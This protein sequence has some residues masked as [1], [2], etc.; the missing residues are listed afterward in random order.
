MQLYRA[1]ASKFDAYSIYT[2]TAASGAMRAYGMPQVT[3]AMESHMDDIAR[4][5]GMDPIE[6]RNRNR[7]EVGFRD[8]FTGNVNWTDSHGAWPRRSPARRRDR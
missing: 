8:S 2:N 6:L 7:M 3:F 1:E 5:L 4:V